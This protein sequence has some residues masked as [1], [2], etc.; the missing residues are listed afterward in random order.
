MPLQADRTE[1][2]VGVHR[3]K[4]SKMNRTCNHLLCIGLVAVGGATA[5]ADFTGQPLLGP[6]SNLSIVTNTTAGKTD[7]N[8]GF[9][10]GIHIFNI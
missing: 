9:D 10:S 7:D 4:Q 3:T 1:G 5:R 8:D 6:L 2:C